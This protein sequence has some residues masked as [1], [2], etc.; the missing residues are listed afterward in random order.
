MLKAEDEI[1]RLKKERGEVGGGIWIYKP[2]CM[3]RGR[4][5][6]V[7]QGKEALD[8][9]CNGSISRVWPIKSA[10]DG[11]S[12]ESSAKEIPDQKLSDNG[13][14]LSS[15]SGSAPCKGI[16]QSYLLDPLLV[17][18]FKF[19]VRCYLLVA[20]NDPNYLAF[21]HPGYFRMTLKP[22]TL[23]PESLSDTSVHLTNA[24]GQ[25]ILIALHILYIVSVSEHETSYY[26]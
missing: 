12:I 6:Y 25:F 16:V 4:G 10:K 8:E 9:I 3:N 18:G 26:F 24:A 7:L 17:Q 23:D 1:A 2:S 19:D 15:T 14:I 22:Y 13:V 11:G 21:Y 5:V 20:R